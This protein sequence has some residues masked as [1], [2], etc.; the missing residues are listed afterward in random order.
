LAKLTAPTL[1][2]VVG[3]TRLFR[4]LD[5]STK[6][7]VTWIAAPPGAGK[8]TL[9]ASYAH[10]RRR[11]LLWYRLDAGD[12]D[13]ATFFHYLGLAAKTATPQ[14]RKGLPRLTPEYFAGLPIFTQRF[15]EALAARLTRPTL[16]VF[17]NYHE[18]LPESALHQLLPVGIARLP[19]HIRVVIL[20][21]ETYPQ[22]YM[23]LVAGQQLEN[24]QPGALCLTQTEA[25]EVYRLQSQ[26]RMTSVQAHASDQLWEDTRGWM[27][28]FLLQV[29]RGRDGHVPAEVTAQTDPQVVFEYLAGEVLARLAIEAQQVLVTMSLVPDFTP[30]MAV[31]LTGHPQAGRILEGLHRTRYFIERREDRVGWYRYH[32]LFRTFLLQRAAHTVTVE[33]LRR[34]RESAAS[35]LI[36]VGLEGEAAEV[37][38]AA[39]AWDAYRAL[40]I[41]SAHGLMQQGRVHTVEAW[42]RR[43]PECERAADP[44][45]DLWLAQCCAGMR[46]HE[47]IALYES[48]FKQ[49]RERGE[50]EPMLLAWAGVVQAIVMVQSGI[51]RLRAWL[52]IFEEIHPRGAVFPSIDVERLVVD[53]VALAYVYVAPAQPE[54]R[55]WLKQNAALQTRRLPSARSAAQHFSEHCYIWFDDFQTLGTLL[56]RAREE[57]KQAGATPVVRVLYHVQEASLAWLT[58]EVDICRNAAKEGLALCESS[59]LLVVT[60]VLIF[61]NVYNELLSGHVAAAR[62]YL[63]RMKPFAETIGG[64]HLAHYYFLSSWAAFIEGDIDLAWQISEQGRALINAEESPPCS[65]S[66][67][68]LV[69][70]QVLAKRGQ[71]EEAERRLAK[72]EALGQAMPSPHLLFGVYCIRAQ[73][74]F[75]DGDEVS[76]RI[77]LKRLLE[78]GQKVPRIGFVGWNPYEASR[79]LAKALDLKMDVPYVVQVIRKRQLKPP[80]DG[81]VPEN[82]PWRLRIRTFGKLAVEVDGKPLEKQ[83]KAPHRLLELLAAIIAFGG[84]DVPVSRLID[85]LWPEADGD[86]GHENF[87]KSIARLRKLLAVDEVIRWE[88]GKV[89]LNR[90]LC[91]VD[92][93]TFER[94]AK[95]HDGRAMALYAGPFLGHEQ[96][97]AWAEFRRDHDRSRF[98]LLVNRH[99]DEAHTAGNVEEAIRSLERAIDADPMAEPL[100]QRLIPVLLAQGRQ[101]DAAAQF[102][103]CRTALARWADRLPSPELQALVHPIRLR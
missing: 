54:A 99:C 9:L 17:D 82:W 100:Y 29:E 32:P 42:I 46:P 77:W 85:A 7:V 5:Q 102:D 34:I 38:Q 91:W 14:S 10:R 72:V 52:R 49:F 41:R 89:S 18:V 68:H 83:R 11:P 95:Q 97:P 76:G 66:L 27:A 39:A 58:G 48:A 73:W 1:P 56:A 70:S 84:Q 4:L 8:T 47:A 12:A 19:P 75:D 44:W 94:Q 13:P 36:E 43:L 86:T 3:R 71:R 28:G 80:I 74:A 40:I 26:R 15:F 98:V 67:H 53:A 78:E 24:L 45:M 31:A 25:A 64:M 23:Q 50:R 62:V 87:K 55:Q 57:S 2:R 37:L 65:S 90:D 20:S 81:I 63:D 96:I 6:S 103:R 92:A 21:R 30:Q 59:G 93:L 79:L 101:A 33:T 60:I 51:P 22:S 61:Q 16:V 88:D 35:L 69:E